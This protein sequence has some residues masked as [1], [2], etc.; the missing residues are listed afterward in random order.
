ML[1]KKVLIPKRVLKDI[2]YDTILDYLSDKYEF[3]INSFD[4]KQD[5]RNIYAVNIDW[6]TTD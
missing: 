2:Q 1:P 3:C 6:D 4:L 5:K